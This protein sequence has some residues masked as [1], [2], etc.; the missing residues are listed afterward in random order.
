MERMSEQAR[1]GVPESVC[2][3]LH[4]LRFDRGPVSLD[5]LDVETLEFADRAQLTPLLT[6]LDLPEFARARASAALERNTIRVSRVAAA[7]A[8]IAPA[9]DHVVL[10]GFTHVPHFVDDARLRVQY[11]LDLF[12]PPEQVNAARD[13]LGALGYE[14]VAGMEKLAMDHHP[15]MIRK[16]G[17]EWRGDYFDPDIPV[18]VEIH[19]QFWDPATERLFPEGLDD[20]WARRSGARLDP[21]DT[22]GYA[23][24]HLCRHLLRGNLRVFQVWEVAR[25]LHTHRVP[26]FWRTW[27]RQHSP[28]LRRVE[29]VGFL[30][31][32][33]WF[34]CD[35]PAQ[36]RDEIAAL[37]ESVRRWFDLHGWSPVQAMFRPNKREVLLH[38]SL[39]ENAAD[40]LRI[41]RRRLIPAGLPGPVDAVHLPPGQMTLWRTAKQRARYLAY[42]SSRVARHARLFAP[43]LGSSLRW[44]THMR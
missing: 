8:E 26:A 25:F 23:A 16:T 35:L 21:V 20:F 17:W 18:S 31:A 28:S 13:A 3:L 4:R 38:L 29:S 27:K 2:A 33:Q 42:V 11:D 32:W 39:V 1:S 44:W 43:T 24:L 30:L 19:F 5:K 7:Y 6:R 41:L 12:V 9:F 37:P 15:P 14:P 34:G 22:L 40:R 36:V 10:K